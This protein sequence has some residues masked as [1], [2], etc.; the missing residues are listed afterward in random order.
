MSAAWD[1]FL[2]QYEAEGRERLDGYSAGHFD[3]LDDAELARARAMVIAR[4]ED[5]QTP[6]IRA[7]PLL[8]T[9]AAL[10]VVEGLLARE[11][12]PTLVR[13]AACEAG[14][15]MTHSPGY[16]HEMLRLA[17]AGDDFVRARALTAVTSLPLEPGAF[18]AVVTLLRT[19]EDEVIA[20]EL[21]QG[22]LRSRGV[23]V[24][25]DEDFERALPLVRALAAPSLQDRGEAIANLDALIAAH[26][27]A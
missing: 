14:W 25:D 15:A 9:P 8:R 11:R 1:E 6:E 2:A 12:G 16:Q 22:V 7:L 3:G 10:P 21:A 4:A 24:D 5:G 23:A 19:E 18:E 26:R 17:E 20:V 27:G 13:L